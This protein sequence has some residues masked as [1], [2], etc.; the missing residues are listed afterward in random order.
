MENK[1]SVLP[2]RVTKTNKRLERASKI[3][4]GKQG[5]RHKGGSE[6]KSGLASLK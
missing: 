5:K 2:K 3:D 6:E 4:Q 1:Y